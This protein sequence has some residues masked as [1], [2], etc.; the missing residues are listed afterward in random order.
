M[1]NKGFSLI[2]VT[3]AIALIGIMASIGVPKL[4]R[5]MA[6]G[7]DTKAIATLGTLRTA[8]ELYFIENSKPLS[9]TPTSEE[10]ENIT[11]ALK[12]LEPYLDEKTFKEIEDGELEIGG[13]R[14]KKVDIDEADEN[15]TYGGTISLTFKNP[16]INKSTGSDGVYI[17]FKPSEGKEYDT[18]GNVM[19]IAS[20]IVLI[21]I[22]LSIIMWI[23]IKKLYIPNFLNLL[24]LIIAIYLKKF[25]YEIIENSIIGMGIYT[26]PLLFLY[27]YL[28]DILNKEVFGFGDIK[29]L[30]TLGYI[31]GYSNFFDIYLFYLISFISASFMGIILL[32]RKTKRKEIPFSPFLIIGFLFLWLR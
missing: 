14:A 20:I 18:K 30:M 22:I 13:S 27:G 29:L 19:N 25:D 8:S 3:V 10:S 31:L 9:E 23:D 4:R 6:L 32:I 15:I 2:E 12:K 16:D 17:W 11:T 24:L 28:S 21:I 26:L 7:R 1:K 5:Q